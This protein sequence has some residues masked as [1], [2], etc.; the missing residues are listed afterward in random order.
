MRWWATCAELNAARATPLLGLFAH[1][2]MSYALDRDMLT[3]PGLPEMTR[4]ALALLSRRPA[5]FFL[6]VEGSRIDHAGHANDPAS[7]A[8]ELL[9][10]D[11][12]LRAV[13][14]FARR[15]G[16]TL[17]VS[18]RGPQTGGLS[19]GRRIGDQSL[20]ELHIETLRPVTAS[21]ERMADSIAAGEHPRPCSLV[22]SARPH[23]P[24]RRR[25]WTRRSPPE[26]G[27]RGHRRDRE[28]PRAGRLELQRAHRGRR[29]PLRHGQAARASADTA[30]H[31]HRPLAGRGDGALAGAASAGADAR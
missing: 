20:Y 3:Q 28:P 14:D 29:R 16:H 13:L 7:H 12:A 21:T 27:Q 25:W 26:R 22:T 11:A 1:D 31:R 19:L 8:R 6:M 18:H 9:E 2:D 30:E 17:V 4:K 5:G 10:Y 15:D 23:T 24:E